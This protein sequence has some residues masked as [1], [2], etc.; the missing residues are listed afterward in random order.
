MVVYP[1]NGGLL[2][3]QIQLQCRYQS[4]RTKEVV[5]QNKRDNCWYSD[6]TTIEYLGSGIFDDDEGIGCGTKGL[7]NRTRKVECLLVQYY[8]VFNV[9]RVEQEEPLPASATTTATA[10]LAMQ[11]ARSY[12]E[13]MNPRRCVLPV[14]YCQ[15]GAGGPGWGGAGHAN[16][17]ERSSHT[18]LATPTVMAACAASVAEWQQNDVVPARRNTCYAHIIVKVK[19]YYAILGRAVKINRSGR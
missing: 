18:M 19:Y 15:S 14:G 4:T 9:S 1:Q 10:L 16:G 2:T 6:K 17:A 7:L 3:G 12:Q 8:V 5:F 13:S 11:L